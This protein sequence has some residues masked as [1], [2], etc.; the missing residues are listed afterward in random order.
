MVIQLGLKLEWASG[1][2]VLRLSITFEDK[3]ADNLQLLRTRLTILRVLA[4][5]VA[6]GHARGEIHYSKISL[7]GVRGLATFPR[8]A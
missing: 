2:G 4:E 3:P 8:D 1:T 7:C 5:E 6:N